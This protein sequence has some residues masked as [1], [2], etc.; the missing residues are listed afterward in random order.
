MGVFLG[1]LDRATFFG[2]SLKSK[3]PTGMLI[4]LPEG[5]DCIGSDCSA[6]SVSKTCESRSDFGLGLD[7]DFFRSVLM[8]GKSA[9]VVGESFTDADCG[10]WEQLGQT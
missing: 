5:L 10:S 7:L 1:F 3:S 2:L 9:V 6:A 4:E 8:P